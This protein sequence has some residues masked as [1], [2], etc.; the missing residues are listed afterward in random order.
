M[1]V[2]YAEF[3]HWEPYIYKNTFSYFLV[4]TGWHD[5]HCHMF[6]CNWPFFIYLTG[7]WRH[8]CQLGGISLPVCGEDSRILS[9]SCPNSE[10]NLSAGPKLASLSG[11]NKQTPTS[12]LKKYT[13][14]LKNM[15][16]HT[17]FPR[18]KNWH[19]SV[20]WWS[21]GKLWLLMQMWCWMRQTLYCLTSLV[22][23]TRYS[24]NTIQKNLYSAMTTCFVACSDVSLLG[25]S[26][27]F[28]VVMYFCS[29]F[30][31]VVPSLCW[32]RFP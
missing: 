20:Y 3:V 23:P 29:L 6:L 26:L 9:A 21:R 17:L 14:A 24:I 12:F 25:F 4:F 5:I 32:F 28:F 16:K 27:K 19:M 8:I 13:S 18:T 30:F 10:K 2:L 11:K 15:F 31:S 7:W 22:M 1:L